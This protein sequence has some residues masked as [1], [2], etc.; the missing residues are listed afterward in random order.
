MDKEG[1]HKYTHKKS[2]IHNM[3]CNEVKSFRSKQTRDDIMTAQIGF[4]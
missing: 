3:M 4:Y 2:N 1:E